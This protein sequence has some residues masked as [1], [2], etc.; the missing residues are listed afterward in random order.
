MERSATVGAYLRD[1]IQSAACD[2]PVIGDV[3]GAGLFVGVELVRD[4]SS[5]HPAPDLAAAVVNAMRSRRV[6]IS[7]T[8][9]QGHVLKIRPPLPFDEKHSDLLVEALRHSIAQAAGADAKLAGNS[10]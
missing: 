6:L 1:A 5:K 10:R 3:R 8:G 7:A 4:R 9:Q 2:F